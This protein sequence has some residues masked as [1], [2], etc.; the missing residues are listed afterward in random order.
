VVLRTGPRSLLF[1]LPLLLPRATNGGRFARCLVVFALAIVLALAT[2]ASSARAASDLLPDLRMPRLTD[3]KI[4]RTSD[5]RKLLRF[6]SIIVNV[7]DGPLRVHGQRPDTGAPTMTTFQRIFD[8]AGETRDVPT[9][10]VMH[11]GGDGHNHWHVR[12]LESFELERL[13]NGSKVG[14][15]AKH[16][17]CFWDNHRYGS[18]Q[19]PYYTGCG[20]WTD[21]EVTM[22]L[23]VGWG[24]LYRYNLPDQYIDITGLGRGRYRL[25]GT[26]DAENWFR[27]SEESNNST[28]VDLR[29]RNGRATVVGYGP[30]T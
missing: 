21:L 17:F 26:A 3:L 29:I 5:G 28:W 1:A 30:T 18:G 14:A 10:A 7:G 22:G 19:D 4:E 11:F 6:S 27:E 25:V 16:G 2:L 20:Q 13:R 24:D 8:E 9:D 15:G 12:D 23:S